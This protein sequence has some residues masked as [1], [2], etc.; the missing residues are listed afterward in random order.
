VAHRAQ[1]QEALRESEERLAFAIDAAHDG[2]WDWRFDKG[3]YYFSSRC[4]AA[5][6]Y[7]DEHTPKTFGEW[8]SLIHPDD[9]PKVWE[10]RDAH[11]KGETPAYEVE[12]RLRAKSGSWRWVLGK[13]KII[14]RDESGHPVRMVG[15][16]TDITEQKTAEE[17]QRERLR[18]VTTYSDAIVR[19]A[20]HPD[21]I[22]GNVDSAVRVLTEAVAEATGEKRV[23][24]WLLED[25]GKQL[26]CGDLFEADSR[27]HS[28]GMVLLADDYPS[29]FAALEQGRAIA[30]D[31]ACNDPRTT[32]SQDTYLTPFGITSVLGAAIRLSGDV[33]GAVCVEHQGKPRSWDHEDVT[34]ASE[35]AD[36]AAQ[37]LFNAERKKN[38]RE[39]RELEAR[40]QQTQKLESL[41]VLAG[42]IAHD[43]NNLL[44]AIL[45]N[46]ELALSEL[47]PLSPACRHLQDIESASKHA[48][49]LCRQMLAYSGKGRFVIEHVDLS[50]LAGEMVHL[51]KSSISKKVA[52]NLHLAHDLPA[53]EADTAQLQQL[54]M[55]LI[56]NASEAIGDNTGEILVS[57]TVHECTRQDIDANLTREEL[58]PGDYVCLEVADTGCGM[59]KETVERIFDPFFTTKFTGRGLGLAAALGIVRGH[60]GGLAVESEVGKGTRF[61]A[62][63]PA[64]NIAVD[65]AQSPV[66]V[67]HGSNDGSRLLLAEDENLVRTASQKMLEK[68]GFEVMTACDGSEAVNAFVENADAIDCVVLDVTMPRMSGEE[69]Y[70]EMLK[71]RHDLRVVFVSGYDDPGISGRCTDSTCTRFVR[72][73]YTSSQIVSCIEELLHPH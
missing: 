11:L 49:D 43:F 21:V 51:L 26:R 52:L 63:F 44:M 8:E 47:S 37:I 60:K 65:T 48:A 7:G 33:S 67:T 12:L 17:Q 29:Y 72:K 64:S 66:E 73:P 70:E 24:V 61:R 40:F 46:T 3:T 20:R 58:P 4:F 15:V 45:G 28:H 42:G 35:V 53:I 25:G 68:A 16:V 56:T 31:N 14:A 39:R 1:A 32:E 34:F 55:N 41:G 6:G 5:L 2:H 19:L 38:R 59:G 69:A 27:R 57:T 9:L 71:T 22:E 62:C 23:S 10:A 18:R 13:G 30:V 54:L 36:Q 50:E